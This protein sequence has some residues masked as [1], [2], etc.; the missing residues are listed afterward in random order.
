METLRN[1]VVAVSAVALGLSAFYIL[2]PKFVQNL[3]RLVLS[4]HYSFRV[5]GL[6]NVPRSGPVLIVPNH[7]SWID[8]LILAAVTPR[9]GKALVN[10]GFVNVPLL[11]VLLRRAGNIPLP[12]AGPRAIRVAIASGRAALDRGEALGMFPE[13]QI[14]RNGLLGPCYRGIEL[15][16]RDRENVPVVPMAIDNLWGS[17]FSRSGGRF[18]RKWPKGLRRTVYIA[19]GPPVLPPVTAFAVRQALLETLVSAYELRPRP[20]PMLDTLDPAL[21]R[22]EHPTLGLLTASCQDIL[23]DGITQLG[24]KPGTVGLPVPGV[25]IRVVGEGGD[26][27]PPEKAGRIHALLAHHS[28]WTDTG[29]TGSI[30]PDGFL[31]TT[32][33]Q[34]P[35]TRPDPTT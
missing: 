31:R 33:G 5:R 18:F 3:I 6:E 9:R 29:A 10:A 2:L 35:Q 13:G 25:A 30:D 15:V 27:L 7:T 12:F 26:S 4:L 34:E 16:L 14:S 23:L 8:G 20:V 32:P 1:W 17:L 11:G 21:P 28:G 24:H 19:F 22:W